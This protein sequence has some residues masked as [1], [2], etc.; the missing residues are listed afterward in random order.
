MTSPSA[1]SGVSR[2]SNPAMLPRMPAKKSAPSTRSSA[3][4]T[5]LSIS[6]GPNA[7][8]SGGMP[9]LAHSEICRPIRRACKS[10][11]VSG[12][13]TPRYRPRAS[14]AD[15]RNCSTVSSAVRA[16][17]LL[18]HFGTISSA[19]APRLRRPFAPSISTLTNNCGAS[20][21]VTA[22]KRNGVANGTRRSDSWISLTTKSGAM[23]VESRIRKNDRES[24]A[25]AA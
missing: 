3:S 5:A 1:R 4:S 10:N 21:T 11:A 16:G 23:S 15:V 14:S 2:A 6:A 13:S 24:S 19:L 18:N 7:A 17:S 12:S 22:P 9:V 8:A 20:C 25:R